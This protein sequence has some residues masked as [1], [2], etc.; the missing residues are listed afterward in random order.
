MQSHTVAATGDMTFPQ[1]GRPQ[2]GAGCLSGKL[3]ALCTRT[4]SERDLRQ[5]ARLLLDWCG[6]AMAATA[7][8]GSGAAR[9]WARATHGAGPCTSFGTAEA[10]PELAAFVNGSLGTIL[11][12]DDLHRASI[13]HAGNVVIPAALAA[14]QYSAAPARQLLEAIVVGYEVALRIGAAASAAGYT[15][16][17][18]SGVCGGFGAAM[19]AAHAAGASADTKIDA[20][21]HAGMQ[22]SGLWQCRLETTD[23]KP[24]ATAHAARAGITSAF[25]AIHGCRGARHILDGRLGFFSTY[26]PKADPAN[27][28]AGSSDDWKLHEVSFKPWPACRHVHTAVGLALDLRGEV[29][30]EA[31]EG[32]TV[33][34]YAAA[35]DFCDTASP[36]NSHQARFSLQHC[37]AVALK[38]G[39]L[40]LADVQQAALGDA[41]LV[42]LRGLIRL[43]EDPKLSAAFPHRMGAR[44]DI[45]GLGE[46]RQSAAAEDAPGDPEKPMDEAAL[47]EKFLANLA[48]ADVGQADA[49]ILAAAI[50]A[51]P[52]TDRLERL[53][54]GL[55]AVTLHRN[56][57]SGEGREDD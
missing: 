43:V 55:R 33:H 5:A 49:R 57:N 32:V 39:R 29:D 7:E 14:A 38:R 21:G 30:V 53:N 37:V 18:N 40:R 15:A 10:T 46:T 28:L 52:A 4:V 12:M 35:I 16:W 3:V 31:I 22:A 1:A 41:D 20:L 26:Y 13:M 25:M 9:M 34:T 27:V 47:T 42:R 11:E 8:P 48:W 6:I 56:D 54:A 44:L 23:S 19:A 50:T 36:Q 51:L 17:Y 45:D 2:D 24:L